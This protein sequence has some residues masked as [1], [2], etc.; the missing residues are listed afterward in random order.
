[1]G[2]LE[3]SLIRVEQVCLGTRS[4]TGSN[5][6]VKIKNNLSLCVCE[7]EKKKENEGEVK[8]LLNYTVRMS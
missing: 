7:K 3:R 4:S 1:M 8:F 2:W 6:E 5:P